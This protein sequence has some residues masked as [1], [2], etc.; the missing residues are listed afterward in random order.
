M[1]YAVDPAEMIGTRLGP[2]T[3]TGLIGHGGMGAVYRAVREHDFHMQVAIKLIKRGADTAAALERFR[4]ER[5]ILAGLQHPNIA[6]L[7]DGGSTG[8]G[9]P[10]FVMEYIDGQPLLQ[11]AAHLPVG[12]RLELFRDVCLAV[13]YAHQ[14]KIVH[15]DIKP[16][17][18][19]VTADGVPKLLDFG[20]AKLL[21]PNAGGTTTIAG[22]PM[23]PDYASPEQMRGEPVT[24][25]TDIYSLGAV[26]HEL[27]AGRRADR[28]APAGPSAADR[29]LDPILDTIVLTALRTEPERRY[30]TAADFA[31]D[32]DR[33]LQHRPI[34]ARSEGLRHRSLVF[35]RRHRSILTAAISGVLLLFVLVGGIGRIRRPAGPAGPSLRSIAVLPLDNLS[36]NRDQDYLADGVTD[37]LIDALARNRRLRVISRAS[38]MT[39]KSSPHRMQEIARS[40][41]VQTVADGSVER[42]GDRLRITVRLVDAVRNRDIWSA[43]Y[44]GDLSKLAALKSQ[45]ADAIA[46]EMQAGR[47]ATPIASREVLAEAQD[48]YLR[49]RQALFRG[50]VEDVQSSIQL[51]QKALQIEPGYAAAYAGLSESYLLL[52]GMYLTPREAMAKTQAAA[53]RALELDP[54][55]AEAHIA[56]GVF[57][58]WYEF[59]WDQA[60]EEFRRALSLNPSDADA[61]NWYGQS[62]LSIGR[63]DEG[64][65]QVRLAHQSDPL[66]TFIE[67]GLGQAYFLS[68]R[69]DQA[70]RQLRNVAE[71]DPGFA[72]GRMFLGVALLYTGQFDE[73]IRELEK[74]RQLDPR[75]PQSIAYL[76]YAYGKRGD[77]TAGLRCLRQLTDLKRERYVSGYLFA[78]ASLGLGSGD[79]LAGLRQAYEDRDDMLAWLKMDALLDPLRTDPGFALLLTRVGLDGEHPGPATAR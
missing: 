70:L 10:Y 64:I 4:K 26:L 62:L 36:G 5:Q 11:Y 28:D 34:E 16:A 8:K 35:V 1:E 77:H 49:G 40:L 46:V 79:A 59:S 47:A 53:A 42:D 25:T 6:H 32:I 12:R 18:I 33:Y 39:F 68:R 69:Y 3:I 44:Q 66:S 23:T 22:I 72:S 54:D 43:S 60:L 7:L 52:S 24:P 15:R 63:V 13:E 45:V 9:L 2:Y 19:L 51:F 74:A 57:R 71:S 58:G 73:A 41:G 75:Q 50:S 78:I 29:D 17:N 38:T 65:H 14:N 56:M 48:S 30:R 76:A 55:S 31:A 21:D 61:R 20:I 37:A 67:T 27:L